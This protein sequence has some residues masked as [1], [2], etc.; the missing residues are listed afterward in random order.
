MVC[1]DPAVKSRFAE[2][3]LNCAKPDVMPFPDAVIFGVPT[4]K[5]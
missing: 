2:V 5:S 4:V 1:A 3:T